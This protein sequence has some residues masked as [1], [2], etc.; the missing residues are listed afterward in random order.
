MNSSEF[1]NPASRIAIFEEMR[2]EQMSLYNRRTDLLTQ[3]DSSRP[4]ILDKTFVQD[5]AD[6]LTNYNE[7][8]STV[9]DMLVDNLAKDM[10]NTNED[11]D[12]AYADVLDF[13]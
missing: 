13:L 11:I 2:E 8:S 1:V 10:D 12:I 9:F 7:E 5:I 6:K 3:L 4:T